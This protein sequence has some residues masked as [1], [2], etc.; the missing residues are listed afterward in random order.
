VTW[1]GIVRVGLHVRDQGTTTASVHAHTLFLKSISFFNWYQSLVHS[2]KI[3]F[4]SVIFDFYILICLKLLILFL[5]SMVR[6]MAIG[7]LGCDS[8]KNLLTVG[9]LLTLVGLNQRMQ[10]PKQ[11]L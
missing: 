7:K 4:L 5:P 10:L 11:S 8:F 6:T 1:L 2:E 3:N 9:I